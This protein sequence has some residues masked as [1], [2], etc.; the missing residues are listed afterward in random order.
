MVGERDI[1]LSGGQKQRTAIARAIL[2]SP[3]ILVLDYSL[4]NVDHRIE[5]KIRHAIFV[6]ACAE[7]H[8]HL[9]STG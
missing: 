1:A 8:Y 5:D 3:R 9:I 7:T 2:R 6:T 4:S